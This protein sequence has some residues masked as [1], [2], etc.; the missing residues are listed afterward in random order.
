MPPHAHA[1][2]PVEFRSVNNKSEKAGKKT[3]WS[4]LSAICKAQSYVSRKSQIPG[5]VGVLTGDSRQE[6]HELTL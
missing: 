5:Y 4:E 3:T 2:V 6:L 1:I